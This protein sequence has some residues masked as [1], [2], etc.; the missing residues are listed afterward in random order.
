MIRG[1]YLLLFVS[2]VQAQVLEVKQ[3][4]NKKIV[5]VKRESVASTKHF[6]ATTKLDE[7]KIVD[8]TLRFGG[9]VEEIEADETFQRVKKGEKL[10]TVYSQTLSEIKAEIELAKELGQRKIVHNLQKKLSLLN[11]SNRISK[12]YTVDIKAP[13]SGVIWKKHIN[14]GSFIKRGTLVYQIADMSTMWVVF[15]AYQK[16][17]SFIQKGMDASIMI[18]G[19]APL[20]GK[21]D[22]IY[23]LLNPQTKT[24]DVR[25][26]IANPE[27]KIFPNLFA[28]V[29]IKS[30]SKPRLIV[31]KSAVLTK[32]EKHFAFKPV[33]KSEFE[34]IMIEAHRIDANRYVIDKGLKEGD[35]IIDKALFM[36]DSDALT[37]GLYESDEDEEW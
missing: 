6:Y 18:E 2:I 12:A 34:P 28:K 32:G 11:A 35:K 23:P 20:E 7:S 30:F 33:G 10:F 15:Q 3:L 5:K 17:L 31:P 13:I 36:L 24:V 4:F 8:V 19:F 25:I 29:M 26:K 16:D 27:Y 14:Q 9:F 1:L 21:V 37:N 22:F